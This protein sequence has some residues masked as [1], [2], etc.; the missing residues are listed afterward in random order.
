[1]WKFHVVVLQR[2]V[3]ILLRCLVAVMDAKAP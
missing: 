1:M 2:T 3:Q